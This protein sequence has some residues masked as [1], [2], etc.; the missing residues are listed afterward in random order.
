MFSVILCVIAVLAF[1][2]GFI[3]LFYMKVPAYVGVVIYNSLWGPARSKGPGL[4][5]RIPFLE[6][7]AGEHSIKERMTPGEMDAET[8]DEVPVP[9]LFFLEWHPDPNRLIS[10][11]GFE[12]ADIERALVG[13]FKS[14]ASVIVRSKKKF[15]EVYDGLDT[16]A[17]EIY[18]DFT[19]V[20][21]VKGQT[22][23][24]HYGIILSAARFSDPK[25]P[26]KIVQAKLDLEAMRKTNEKH[27]IELKN[28]ES[29]AHGLVK[30][31]KKNGQVMD[32]QT[33]LKTVQVHLGIIT[34]ENRNYGLNRE[35]LNAIEKFLK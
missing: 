17:T 26:D 3:R 12:Q 9:L 24:D 8:Q 6:Y 25:V 4:R 18:K 23:E 21:D 16:I 15:D 31:A 29:M 11:V 2:V 5:F 28:L 14:I 13:R 20:K 35:T 19:E 33:A 1:A 10:Y 30:K 32:Y 34:E 7:L 27:D 22:L